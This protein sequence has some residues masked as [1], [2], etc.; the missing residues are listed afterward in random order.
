M[1]RLIL[2]RICLW[3]INC[4][5]RMNAF[6]QR[7]WKWI[8]IIY[9][10]LHNLIWECIFH[11][12]ITETL[13]LSLNIAEDNSAEFRLIRNFINSSY[14]LE[15]S[16][17][18][19]MFTELNLQIYSKSCVKIW[20]LCLITVSLYAQRIVWFLKYSGF[21]DVYCRSSKQ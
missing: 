2:Y 20:M 12:S 5:K 15:S 19:V 11:S 7:Q 6:I 13:I 8:M 3:L 17:I 21:S 9:V 4:L 18:S 16:L 1:I 14:T 10:P